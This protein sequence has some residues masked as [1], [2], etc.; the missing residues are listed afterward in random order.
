LATP[1]NIMTTFFFRRS[2]E[3]AFQLD[4]YPNGL[5]LRLIK[6]IDTSPPFI[7]TGVDDIAFIVN[8]VIKRSL[9]TSHKEVITST[10]LTIDRVLGSDFVGMIQRKMRDE[11]YPKPLVQGGFPPEDKIIAFI[12]LINSVDTANEYLARIISNLGVNPDKAGS[13]S[14]VSP[15]HNAFPSEAD[16]TFVATSLNH[17]LTSFTSKT[18]ELLNDGLKVLFNQVVKL[19]LV[20]I[21]SDTFRAVDYSLS[22]EELTDAVGEEEGNGEGGDPMLPRFESGWGQLMQP[23]SRIMAP[24]MYMELL[25]LTSRHLARVLEKRLW[26]YAGRT[27]AFGAVRMERDFSGIISV[28]TR[29]NYSVR[30]LFSRVSQILMVVNME[31]DEWEEL[32]GLPG[33][34]EG[35]DRDNGVLWVLTGE[36]RARARL[37]LKG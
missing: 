11:S 2:V 20:S 17:L 35:G 14:H 18:T 10:I 32:S 33:G 27:S 16:L 29:G 22:G 21:L 28:V 5:S 7:I 12:V 4:E 23:I 8:T 6:P 24:K 19:R 26:G 13:V 36:E 34:S 30:E 37:L 31:E 3:K 1:Y 9:S 15:V 25:D